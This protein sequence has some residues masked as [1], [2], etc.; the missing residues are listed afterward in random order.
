V[1]SIHESCIIRPIDRA[2]KLADCIGCSWKGNKESRWSK[3]SRNEP[4]FL[5]TKHPVFAGLPKSIRFNDESYWN[6]IQRD[7]VE[8][9]GA[10]VTAANSEK[11]S[12]AEV[13]RSKGVRGQAFW[14]YTSGKGRVFGT[15]TGHFTYTYHDPMYRLLL[16]RGIA[17]A[18]EEKPGAFIPIVF[19]GITDDK[20]MVGTRDTMMN[21]RNR[22]K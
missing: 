11:Q 6:M 18:L 2:Q 5:D 17:W 10:V 21:Y 15:T 9:V 8:V 1:V 4:L 12:F 7:K 20:G 14:T 22:K 16:A 19:D 13:L 3:F